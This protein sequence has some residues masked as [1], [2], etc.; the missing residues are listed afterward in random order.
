MFHSCQHSNTAHSPV[1]LMELPIKYL[2]AFANAWR[3]EQFSLEFQYRRWENVGGHLCNIIVKCWFNVHIDKNLCAWASIPHNGDYWFSWKRTESSNELFIIRFCVDIFHTL[4]IQ[5]NKI[6]AQI[7]HARK[8][9]QQYLIFHVI[10][11][12]LNSDV[13]NVVRF[14]I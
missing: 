1:I 13:G 14:L 9:L 3:I 2:M 6:I 12:K 5:S 8:Y 10:T 7:F 11:I 4:Q